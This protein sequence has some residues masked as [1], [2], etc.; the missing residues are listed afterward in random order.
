MRREPCANV[1][2][3]G[4]ELS[5]IR[6]ESVRS[7]RELARTCAN[8][9]THRESA[10][11]SRIRESVANLPRTRPT[12]CELVRTRSRTFANPSR[13]CANLRN[14][15]GE[16]SRMRRES[17]RTS[18]K[19]LRICVK[20]ASSSLHVTR[21]AV[22]SLGSAGERALPLGLGSRVPSGVGVVCNVRTLGSP[23]ALGCE[24]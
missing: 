11:L 23:H 1:C 12:R 8:P 7:R 16:L 20:C 18:A 3:L 13:I 19:L 22:R 21:S 10:N 17:V 9:R 14:P 4:G 24:W 15:G 2:E 5:R 6:R